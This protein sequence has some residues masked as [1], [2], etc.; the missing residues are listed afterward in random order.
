MGLLTVLQKN[1]AILAITMPHIG[2][3]IKEYGIRIMRPV[4]VDGA[5]FP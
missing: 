2:T 3:P 4:S 5:R 1:P